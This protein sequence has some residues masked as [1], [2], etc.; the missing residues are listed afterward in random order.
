LGEVIG[1]LPLPFGD[2]NAKLR[3]SDLPPALKN[4]MTNMV[5]R[6]GK[7]LGEKDG[8]QATSDIAEFMRG[9]DLF[10]QADISSVMARMLRLLT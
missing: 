10:S 5:D 4:L 1:N 3:F 8:K 9:G 7:K 6:V 2:E